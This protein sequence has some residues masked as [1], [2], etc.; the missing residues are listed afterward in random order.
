MILWM[1]RPRWQAGRLVGGWG[2]II[3][4]IGGVGGWEGL[5]NAGRAFQLA[6][7]AS[8]SGLSLTRPEWAVAETL[9][10]T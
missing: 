4:C 5:R 3:L 2:F 10:V 7:R 6:L 1:G 8:C 9:T